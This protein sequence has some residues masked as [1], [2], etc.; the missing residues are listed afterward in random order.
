MAGR[1]HSFP[2]LTVRVLSSK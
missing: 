1:V 2:G